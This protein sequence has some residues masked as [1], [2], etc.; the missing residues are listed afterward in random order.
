M[1]IDSNNFIIHHLKNNLPFAIGKIGTVELNVLYNYVFSSNS[2]IPQI[3]HEAE[4]NAGLT[5]L[6]VN[7]LEQFHKLYTQSLSC[8]N[9]AP[10][11]NNILADFE[12]NILN[13]YSKSYDTNLIDIEPQWYSNPWTHYLKNKTVLVIS[14]FSES[15][16]KQYSKKDLIWPNQLLPEFKLVTIKHPHSGAI[17]DHSMTFFDILEDIKS[18]IDQIDFDF[19]IIGTGATSIPLASYIRNKNKSAIHLGGATQLLFGIR[20]RRWDSNKQYQSLYNE[21]WSRPDISETPQKS[22]LIEEGC[23]W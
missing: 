16:K 14:P 21:H 5:P 17:D 6:T 4:H 13:K 9:I 2:I 7:T 1:K 8:L 19:A 15:I 12:H 10:R 23:Y 11:W 22:K 3:K 20:G 18:K